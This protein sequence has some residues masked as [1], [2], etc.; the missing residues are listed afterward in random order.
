MKSASSDTVPSLYVSNHAKLLFNYN[1]QYRYKAVSM[2]LNGLYK[3]RTP[4]T[5]NAA[6][7]QISKDYFLLNAKVEAHLMED[8]LGIFIQ[9]DNLLNKHYSDILGTAMPDRW[10]MGGLKISL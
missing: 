4:Q 7:V 8:K 10:L 6:F 5:G 1:F 9:A 3:Q 2:A